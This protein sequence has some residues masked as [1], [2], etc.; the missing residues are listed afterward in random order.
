MESFDLI[1]IGAGSGGYPSAIRAA[2]LGS[3]VAIVER[4]ELG[5]ACLN[6]GCIPTKLH[7]EAAKLY[8]VAR[9]SEAM[10]WQ[11]MHLPPGSSS[12]HS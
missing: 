8:H 5:G 9:K 2:Q 7:L 3:S 1:V 10:A 6:W 11:F 4:E 12:T